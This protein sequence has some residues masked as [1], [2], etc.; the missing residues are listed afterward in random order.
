MPDSGDN[1]GS[2]LTVPEGET[3]TIPEGEVEE[4]GLVEAEGTLEVNGTLTT[5]RWGWIELFRSEYSDLVASVEPDR[6]IPERERIEGYLK[7]PF[8][9]PLDEN[10]EYVQTDYGTLLGTYAELAEVMR[11]LAIEVMAERYID[12]AQGRQLERI[13]EEVQIERWDGE[14]ETS[15]RRRIRARYLALISGGTIDD[16]RNSVALLL[17][18]DLD[19]NPGAVSI[20]EPFDETCAY[21]D[22]DIDQAV[23]DGNLIP[24]DYVDEHVR[25][26]KA[27]GVGYADISEPDWFEYRDETY[28]ANA[29]E[30][31]L[32]DRH[33]WDEG[34]FRPRHRDYWFS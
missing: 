4:Y 14:S 20:V 34:R 12:W 21:F 32:G 27:A 11:A 15:L 16:I 28:S 10:G 24:E 30:D 2:I 33:G 1:V 22:I 5:G 9:T 13:G 25:M 31:D 8:K 3:Y 6:D 18:V 29:G 26:A 23:L 17:G 19:A 7:S